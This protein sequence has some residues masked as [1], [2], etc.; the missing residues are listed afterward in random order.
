[1]SSCRLSS[2]LGVRVSHPP[3][4][5]L[6]PVDEHG[7]HEGDGPEPEGPGEEGEG[8]EAGLEEGAGVD[9]VFSAESDCAPEPEQLKWLRD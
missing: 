8:G 7:E 9:E 6:P 5:L 4:C 3:L 1:V 2:D